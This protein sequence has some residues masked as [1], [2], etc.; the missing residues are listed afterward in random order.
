VRVVRVV[1]GADVGRRTTTTNEAGEDAILGLVTEGADVSRTDDALV[2]GRYRVE[3]VLGQ[4]GMGA[5]YRVI[6]VRTERA[7]ALKRGTGRDARKANKRK[8]LLEREY[9]ILAQ[10]AH[11]R[12]IEVYDYGVDEQGPYY[13]MELLDG[14]DLDRRGRLPWREACTLLCDVASSLAILH[15]RGLLHRDVS[16]RNV[17]CTAD[18]RAK[19][20]DFGAMTSM[21]SAKD[22]VGTPPFVAPEAL[23]LQALDARSDLFSLGALAYYLLTA[24]HA[25]P[26]RRLSELRDVW[27]ST[28]QAPLRLVP[29]LPEAL[30]ELVM[31]LCSLDRGARPQS[32]AEVMERLSGIAG[33]PM[34]ERIE[35]TRAYLA[36][37]TLIGRE[38]A[39]IAMR[40]RMLSLVRGEGGVLLCE[41]DSGTGRSRLLD[42]C[43]LE[44]KLLGTTVLRA[45]QGDGAA[46][47]FG[48]TKALCAQLLE[49]F[50][51]M[52]AEASRLSRHVISHVVTGLHVERR[53]SPGVPERSVLL[54]ELRDFV[55]ALSRGQRLVIVVDDVDRIDEQSA[56][57]LAA[58]AH[59]TDRHSVVLALSAERDASATFAPLR[60]LREIAEVIEVAPLDAEQSEAL[61]RAVFGDVAN[62]QLVAGRVHALS[63]GNPRATMELAH[64]LVERDLARYEAGSWSLP[65][66][67]GDDSLPASLAASLDARLRRLGP[68]AR[69]LC[70]LLC[71]AENE[72]L[73]ID[74]Y[75]KLSAH[76]DSRRAFAA[77]DELI[78]ER[79]LNADG[80]RY[81]LS[82]RGFVPVLHAA[83]TDERRRSLAGRLADR[84]VQNQ[85]QA[86]PRKLAEH[87]LDAGR[88]LEAVE[89]LR[90]LNLHEVRMPVALLER[91]LCAAER[92]GL[93]ARVC[94]D[95]RS[96]VLT[97]APMVLA[98]DAFHR[99]LPIV[100]AQLER[101]SGLHAYREL[102]ALPP[103][104][105][106]AQALSRTQARFE[107]TPV[108]ERVY[109]ILDAI[110]EL[111]RFSASFC[112][113][114]LQL[115]EPELFDALPSLE[116]LMP[117]S[118]ALTLVGDV[119]AASKL[120][121][122]GRAM[123]ARAIYE[124]V[125]ARV[126]EPDRA[127]FEETYARGFI[128]GLHYLLGVIDASMAIS[129]AEEHATVLERDRE[130]RVN[131]WRLRIS[132]HLNQGD[133]EQARKC[134]RRAELLQLQE[135][136]Q[137]YL[138]MTV[139]FELLAQGQI[140]DLIA[141][142]RCLE[143]VN[144]LAQHYPGWR[145]LAAIGQCYY[146]SLQGDAEGA[147]AALQPALPALAGRHPYFCYLAAAHVSVL[148]DLGRVDEAIALGRAYY[149]SCQE[150]Q[151]D[152]H[153]RWLQRAL[154]LAL[155]RGQQYAEAAALLDHAIASA[156][157][158][159]IEG[160]SLGALYEARVRVAAGVDDGALL[161]RTIELC[162]SEYRK[163][164]NP[165]LN[166]KFARLIA[167]VRQRQ[168]SQ[169]EPSASAAEL[170]VASQTETGYETIQSRMLECVD[171]DD[172]GR[173]AL[174][175]LLQSIGSL[176]GH[177]YGIGPDR[178]LIAMAALPDAPVDPG[179]E[180]WLQECLRV[181]C[182]SSQTSATA[183]ADG[184]DGD[185]GEL[186][187]EVAARF[188]DRH[189][190]SFEPLFL[191]A[192]PLHAHRLAAVIA[193]QVTP[194]PRS[195]LPKDLMS[196]LADIL[197]DRGD[198]DGLSG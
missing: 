125:L 61:L 181:E 109:P 133:A 177:L 193:I 22:V 191:A 49:L 58:I 87:L 146:R 97:M 89:L 9:H 35:V 80:D 112:S 108:H 62:L 23:A 6:D 160:L 18:G 66:E 101:D 194:G 68:D 158:Q 151:V 103:S 184:A 182:E 165:A 74:D 28:P 78:A 169:S 107:A 44:A 76:G 25:Y 8:A 46:E 73:A 152:S 145:A 135:G 42:A 77:L 63:Q 132:L 90:T 147:L 150:E 14:S 111:A 170:L 179:L 59:K 106:L 75:V 175:M 166:A 32:A 17:R 159:G 139:G 21:G 34:Q 52:A 30:S 148:C 110:R 93:P 178:T 134:Q 71:L 70:D 57:L 117:L 138:G 92:L 82:Q 176:A 53:S 164:K 153:L 45:D 144:R 5:V 183:T 198:V 156:T 154:G 94:Y 167:G 15:S 190:R 161:E 20:L 10:L 38:R 162:A 7:L 131:A 155:V 27:R 136:D 195:P 4:G 84:L 36:T 26:A 172:R 121:L 16:S 83:L 171:R 41:G 1:G 40:R 186:R 104:D 2:A 64:H 163:A 43:V 95:L 55:L 100:L 142:K 127:G 116:P 188:T 141:V 96:A 196:E 56:A 102:S 31:Q 65:A 11:P 91:A 123:P 168:H 24:R 37:P 143:P 192:G 79:V 69:E 149:V 118:P 86:N 120:A 72:Q 157:A 126:L 98:T 124:Q 47:A 12:I 122:R 60:L 173:C 19:L 29:E 51:S 180:T 13:T 189:G 119:I 85:G 88:D 187:S 129:R 185:D 114:A 128:H 130:H 174:T 48:V 105:R 3:E 81:R 99:H 137:R 140:G 50:P 113:L 54:R 39:L 67:L 33:L 115:F 197:L